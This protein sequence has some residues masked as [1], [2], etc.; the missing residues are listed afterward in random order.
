MGKEILATTVPVYDARIKAFGDGSNKYAAIYVDDTGSGGEA[1]YAKIYSSGGMLQGTYI[2]WQ[3]YDLVAWYRYI[4]YEENAVD[5]TTLDSGNILIVFGIIN[6]GAR[7]EQIFRVVLSSDGTASSVL[8]CEAVLP[9]DDVEELAVAGFDDGTA[10][11]Y[12]FSTDDRQDGVMQYVTINSSN[13]VS[14]TGELFDYGPGGNGVKNIRALSFSNGNVVLAFGMDDGNTSGLDDGLIIG[15]LS[16]STTWATALF[17][18]ASTSGYNNYI[19]LG[20]TSTGNIVAT[21]ERFDYVVI[22]AQDGTEILG[23]TTYTDDDLYYMSSVIP[24]I[25]SDKMLLMWQY[26]DGGT[27]YTRI[28]KMDE[29]GNFVDGIVD[30]DPFTGTPG[31][32]IEAGPTGDS[33]SA[34][35]TWPVN[36]EI[37]PQYI[38]RIGATMPYWGIPPVDIVTYKRLVAAA[39]D[40][41]WYEDI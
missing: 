20:E 40:K 9:G 11:I 39:N 18:V 16:G 36:N 29:S 3:V 25:D 13:V 15:V 24:R 10:A 26:D 1:L 17:H 34:V 33:A 4:N 30:I 22:Y 28:R 2:L 37:G 6:D 5:A 27:I 14:D 12:Y 35:I 8:D 31:F 19:G 41:I 23:P 38:Q 32:A 7:A 21:Y